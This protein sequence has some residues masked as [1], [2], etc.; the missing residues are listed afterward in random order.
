M[1]R[2]TTPTV[3]FNF[4]STVDMTQAS[5]VKVTF[6]SKRYNLTKD[7]EDLVIDAHSVSVLLTQEETIKFALGNFEAQVNWLYN[8]GN[9]VKRACSNI[10]V[11]TANE[12]LLNEVW[13]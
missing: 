13:E 4:P 8:E 3:T 11:L 7:S 9:I 6:K 2:A 5:D 1:Y 10:V 12:N